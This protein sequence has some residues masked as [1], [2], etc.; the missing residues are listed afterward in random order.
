VNHHTAVLVLELF[1]DDFRLEVRGVGSQ[2]GVFGA[3]LFELAEY[4]LLQFEAFGCG[5]NDEVGAFELIVI[6]AKD[7]TGFHGIAHLGR[8]GSALDA[9]IYFFM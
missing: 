9:P 7:Y 5:F 8:E 4:L 6:G 1:E 3:E 2:N